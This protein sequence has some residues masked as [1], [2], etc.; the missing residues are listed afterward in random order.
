MKT[1][2]IKGAK[3]GTFF[4]CLHLCLVT[5]VSMSLYV[6]MSPCNPE[7]LS[8]LERSEMAV[9]HIPLILYHHIQSA[10]LVAEA[11]GVE[12]VEFC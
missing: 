12:R 3:L 6:V 4:G 2:L 1:L 10:C 5:E 7:C 9:L 11:L 8:V